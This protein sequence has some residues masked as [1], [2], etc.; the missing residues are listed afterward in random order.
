MGTLEAGGTL[1]CVAV[2][3]WDAWSALGE[4]VGEAT[5]EEVIDAIF[6]EFCIGK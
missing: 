1:D 6:Q 5:P 2:D 3:L 4:V